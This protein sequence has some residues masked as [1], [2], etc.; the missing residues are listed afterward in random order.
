MIGERPWLKPRRSRRPSRSAAHRRFVIVQTR[1]AGLSQDVMTRTALLLALLCAPAPVL[2]QDLV[3]GRVLSG[4]TTPNGTRMA[5]VE[6]TLAPGW[7]T[8]WRAPGEAG[9]PPV[10]DWSASRNVASVRLHWPAPQAFTLNGLTSL[11][12]ADRLVLPV[13]ITPRQEGEPVE[14]DLH[15]ALGICSDVCVPADLRLTGTLTGDARDP[16]ITA[17]LADQPLTAREA[18]VRSV[19]CDV[20]PIADGLRVA[21]RITLPNPDG[22]ETVV[23]EPGGEGIWVSGAEVRREGGDLVAVADMVPPEGAPFAL[24]RGEMRLTVISDRGAVEIAGCPAP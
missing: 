4:W 17:A 3:V 7:K 13:E 12:F 23:M 15:M 1:E 6:L 16:L 8:Y 9:I 10:F 19:S 22:S 21:A 11:G 2:A 20:Q 5:A 18:G 14:L 24:D